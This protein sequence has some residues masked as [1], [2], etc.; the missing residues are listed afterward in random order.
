MTAQKTPL[1]GEP[2]T[3]KELLKGLPAPA[4]WKQ[5]SARVYAKFRAKP[6]KSKISE[7]LE[8]LKGNLQ[9]MGAIVRT[10]GVPQRAYASTASA[11]RRKRRKASKRH[12][13]SKRVRS[14]RARRR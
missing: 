11:Q 4:K 10:T 2:I 8:V 5:F 12:K 9:K 13:P 6:K 3:R 14:R 1:Q 7:S